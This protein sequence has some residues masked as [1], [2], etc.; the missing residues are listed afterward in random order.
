MGLVQAM[1]SNR[2][3]MRCFQ[4]MFQGQW[5]RR[6]QPSRPRPAKPV[7]LAVCHFPT[8]RLCI[9]RVYGCLILPS[10]SWALLHIPGVFEK[11]VG[12]Q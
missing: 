11:G 10:H 5:R 6:R 12:L 9:D 1:S 2:E 8:S 4:A 7:F 3:N